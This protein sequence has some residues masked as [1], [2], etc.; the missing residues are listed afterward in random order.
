[1]DIQQKQQAIEAELLAMIIQHLKNNQMDVVT[2][3]ELAKDFLNLLPIQNREDL[4]SKLKSL[5]DKYAEAKQIY[6]TELSVNVEEK[7]RN[8]LRQMSDSIKKGNIE[9]AISLA[10]SAQQQID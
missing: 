2:A 9:H 6:T 10:K 5:G 1:M 8:A 4:L 3:S 7:E